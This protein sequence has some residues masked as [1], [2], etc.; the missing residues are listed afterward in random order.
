MEALELLEIIGR[1]EDSRHQFKENV[2]NAESLAAEMA[3]FSNSNGGYVVIGINDAGHIV[4][5]DAGNINRLNQLISNA[6]A[7]NVRNPISPKTEIITIDGKNVIVV[8]VL[9]GL[10]K[11]YWDNQGAVWIKNGADKRKVTSKEEM[12]RIFQSVDLIHADEIPVNRTA[13]SDIDFEFLKDFYRKEFE[14]DIDTAEI[15][16]KQLL[17][18]ANLARE[19]ALTLGGLLL[20][21]KYP[22]RYKPEF[23]VKAV[24]FVGNDETGVNYRDSEDITGNLKAQYDKGLAFLLRNLRKMQAGKGFNSLGELEIP[25][26]VVEELLVN[27]LIHRN[28]FIAAPIRLFVFDN[29]VEIISPGKLPNNLTIENIESGNSNIRNP[30]LASFATK[31][32]PYR[33][34]G[35]GIRRALKHY[36][37]IKFVND[38]SNELFK[39]VVVRPVD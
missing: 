37:K 34:I 31:I 16:I 18:N 26:I 35:T 6:A 21:A 27:A 12:R 13:M 8:E 32:L 11:P 22:E 10:D 4:G 33:G 23:S 9:E 3:A 2:N 1:G 15:P 29:R 19:D 7:N 38:V 14:I 24:S 5:L 28:Y 30:L 20:F 39:V 36:S 25:K 17:N